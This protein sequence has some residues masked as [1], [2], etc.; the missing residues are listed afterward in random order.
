LRD[1]RQS[2]RKG[3]RGPPAPSVPEVPVARTR[4][5]WLLAAIT[6]ALP[7][8]LFALVE[9]GLRVAGVGRLEPLFVP[10]E[11]APGHLQPN[12]DFVQRFFPDPRQAPAVSIDTTWFPA[13]KPPGTLRIFV[14]GES[15]AAGFPYGRWASPAALLQQRLQRSFPDREVEVIN[16]GVAA[17]TS[18]VLLD[19]ADEIIAQAP[20]AIVI[21]T[22][23][24][25][26][27]GIGGVGS[28]LAAARSPALART[29]QRLRRLHLYRAFERGLGSL[30]P[31]PAATTEEPRTLMARVA[32]ERS[33]PLGSPLYDAGL[34]Q[35]RGNLERLLAKY[36][37]AGVPVFIG[38]LASNERDQA[39]FVGGDPAEPQSAAAAFARGRELEAAGELTAAR[40]AYIEASDRDALRFRAPS[41]F[42]SLIADVA[43]RHDAELVD[44]NAALAR[45]APGGIIGKEL[46]LEHVHPNVDGYFAL[47]TAFYAPLARRLGATREIDDATARREIPVTE[48]D[49]LNGEYRVRMLMN[50]WPF[51]ETRRPVELPPP[52]NRIEQLAQAWVAGRL[53]WAEVMNNALAEYQRAGNTSEAARVAANLA[54]AFV[55][56]DVAQY[57][58][59]VTLLRDGQPERALRYLR[60][61]RSL[62][63]E[64]IEYSLSLAEALFRN[65]D[66]DGSI[67]VLEAVLAKHPGEQRATY[68][69]QNLRAA[70]APPPSPTP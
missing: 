39:P 64:P 1:R 10:V 5:R 59:G 17:V 36:R 31:A 54:E 61:A 37:A 28:S 57:A 3:S 55:V 62:N 35:F 60:R 44:V 40:G 9:L 45:A 11:S 24:N 8:L 63:P 30:R 56:T 19:V 51:V 68:W 26:Y 15:S 65:G 4:P 6:I 48:P 25:E 20:D 13:R 29:I 43:R 22:G 34:A 14:Q 69:M 7:L 33:I 66:R 50:D 46:M 67:A 18:Y 21:Y 23:H 27:V 32:R 16:T 70:P 47:A 2:N 53:S 41:A 42:N 12:P 58:A 38:T 49:R 52:T